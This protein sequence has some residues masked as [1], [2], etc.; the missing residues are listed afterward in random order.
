M[1]YLEI[2]L[3]HIYNGILFSHKFVLAGKMVLDTYL[4]IG[5]VTIWNEENKMAKEEGNV[6]K[7]KISI[8]AFH[9]S[10]LK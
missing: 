2:Y 3:L 10:G 1:N 8:I 7:D 5:T 4:F 9:P 6:H